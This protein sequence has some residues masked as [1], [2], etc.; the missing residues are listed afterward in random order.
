MRNPQSSINYLQRMRN[1]AIF[2]V[3]YLS[4]GPKEAKGNSVRPVCPQISWQQQHEW[5]VGSEY[6]GRRVKFGKIDVLQGEE[7]TNNTDVLL[8]P[9]SR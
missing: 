7:E 1:S 4:S 8:S 6:K 5:G 9:D 3:L 2:H